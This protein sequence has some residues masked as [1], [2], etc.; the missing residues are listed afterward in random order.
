MSFTFP[1]VKN[2]Q[3]QLSALFLGAISSFAMQPY[4]FWPVLILGLSGLWLLLTENTK[5]WQSLLTGY[6]FAFGYFVAGLWWVGNALLV[7]GNPYLW[8]LPLAVFGLQALLAFFICVAAGFSHKIAP[9]RTLQAF[10]FFVAMM[11]F[12][13]WGRGHMFTGFPW[14]L[15]GM[16]WTSSLSMSQITSVGGIHFLNLATV[17]IFTLPAFLWKGSA[18]LKSKKIIASIA[19][20]LIAANFGWGFNRLNI[21]SVNSKND[22][23]SDVVI[24]IVTPNIAQRDKWN[25]DKL[26][27][28]FWKTVE[29]MR[30]EAAPNKITGNTRVIVLP[31][32]A[33]VPEAFSSPE[34]MN[35]LE[36]ALRA[37]PEKTYLLSGAL[38][39]VETD[40]GELRHY[41]SLIGMDKSGKILGTFD[42]FHL[43]PFGEYIPF[44]KYVPFGPVAKFAGFQGGT[45]PATWMQFDGLPPFSPLICYEAIFAGNVTN[46][47]ETPPQWMVNVTNDAWYGVSP[48]PHQ[49]LAQTQFRAI[50]EGIPMIRSTNTGI[51]AIIDSYGEILTQSPINEEYV[52]EILLPP[53][54]KNRTIYSLYKDKLFFLL[55]SA[56]MLPAVIQKFR[57]I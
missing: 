31:E 40:K 1:F 25:P 13:E 44:Q 32:T 5:L 42:K 23:P 45:G 38:R 7:D 30:P 10:L 54:L 47:D 8:A 43:V 39:R 14:N 28:N 16:T 3:R 50:E 41:N 56:L 17:F 4:E 53:A 36:V 9:G 33:L 55:I 48:G 27:E 24:Q 51:S 29:L 2:W 20:L 11:S 19:V 22:K 37:Y 34:A 12:W 46:L 57:P 26:A 49:H 21:A 15:F 52:Q 35:A 6:L 18:T